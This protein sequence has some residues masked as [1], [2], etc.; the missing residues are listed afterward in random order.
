MK[1]PP[2]FPHDNF[3]RPMSESLEQLL[4]Y[5]RE[6][7]RIC[8]VPM[9]WNALYQILPETRRKGFGWEPPL[10]LILAAW[11]ESPDGDKQERLERSAI[12]I[13]GAEQSCQPISRRVARAPA[14]RRRQISD[15]GNPT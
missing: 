12:R 11:W 14:R 3:I 6:N 7:G 1:E 4:S 9:Q 8:P 13:S 10:P 5:C 15:V 2:F